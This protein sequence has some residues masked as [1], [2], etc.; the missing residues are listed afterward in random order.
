MSTPTDADIKA[1]IRRSKSKG[2]AIRKHR[3][4]MAAHPQGDPTASERDAVSAEAVRLLRQHP[5]V[6]KAWK[7]SV[8]HVSK[9]KY[10]VAPA[11]LPD[12][13]FVLRHGGQF[14]GFESKRPDVAASLSPAQ[15]DTLREMQLAGC[16]TGIITSGSQAIEILNA[17][18]R[19]KDA[20]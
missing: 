7:Q 12:V 15:L 20:G 17:A 4:D 19:Q 8:G 1:A 13:C 16:I 9:S 14:G 6:L 10:T 11:G 5:A 3:A 2:R 18:L